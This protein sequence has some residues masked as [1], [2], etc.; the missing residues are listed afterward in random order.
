MS[1]WYRWDGADLVLRLRV[2]PRAAA[3]GFA[4]PLGDAMKL[5]LTAPPVDGKA[6]A[7]LIALLAKLFGVARTAVVIE[8][9]AQGRAKR[10]RI[11]RPRR[12]PPEIAT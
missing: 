11:A 6:N 1:A 5:R 3:D 4:G 7:H 10:V 2:Q 8:Q 12:L 9:G